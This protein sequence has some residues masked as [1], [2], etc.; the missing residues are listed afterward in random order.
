MAHTLLA[1]HAH[2]DDEVLTTGGTLARAAAEGHRVVVV[3]ATDG[4]LGLTDGGYAGDLAAIRAAELRESARILG[5]HRVEQ[6]GY[7]DSGLGPVVG[8]DPPGRRR[9]VRVDVEEATR[10]LA[11]LIDEERPDVM[12]S[13]D[14]NGG[15]G[16]PDHVQVHLVGRRAAEL[17]AVPRLLEARVSP[18][19]ARVMAPRHVQ[20][21]PVPD[22]AYDLDVRAYLGVKLAALAAHRSQL[23]S[24]GRIPR[25]N[26]L[27]LRLPQRLLAPVMGHEQYADA[28]SEVGGASSAGVSGA[29]SAGGLAGASAASGLAGASSGSI[30]RGDLFAGLAPR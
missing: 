23:V 1:F 11:A 19:V 20:L 6:L 28:S 30:V 8:D 16:H 17:T 26:A 10:A 3:T 2:P 22:A 4:A 18:L 7:A 14:R 13:Y 25:N 29:S 27:L 21:Q 5:V 15:Y 12:L 24:S 9:F